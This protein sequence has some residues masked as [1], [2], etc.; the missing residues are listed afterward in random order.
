MV[1]EWC[2]VLQPETAEDD[3]VGLWVVCHPQ[4]EVTGTL[5]TYHRPTEAECIVEDVHRRLRGTG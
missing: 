2:G 4:L 1:C 5:R 3:A